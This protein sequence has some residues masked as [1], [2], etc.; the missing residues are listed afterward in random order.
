M[1]VLNWHVVQTC[2]IFRT[3]AT[4]GKFDAFLSPQVSILCH[5]FMPYFYC[6]FISSFL[7]NHTNK[8]PQWSSKYS[9]QVHTASCWLQTLVSPS[10]LP[11]APV[12]NY[13]LWTQDLFRAFLAFPI[14]IYSWITGI[15]G[16]WKT[17]VTN[18]SYCCCTMFW[19]TQ[20]TSDF[21]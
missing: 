10:I 16:Q 3:C 17:S 12:W 20:W 5:Q 21:P 7:R 18:S 4:V 13:Q 11:I 1:R 2:L 6:I 8:I 15:L 19:N 14:I 9:K